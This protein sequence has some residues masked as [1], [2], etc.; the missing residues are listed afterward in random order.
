M[1]DNVSSYAVHAVTNLKCH[2]QEST[3][4]KNTSKLLQKISVPAVIL[5]LCVSFILPGI[6]TADN[7]TLILYYSKTNKTKIVAE[8]LKARIPSARLVEIK[9]DVG[10]MTAVLWHQLF[11]RNACTEPIA[12]DL[13]K[14]DTVILCSPVWLQKISSPMRTVINTVPL[15]GKQVKIFAVCAGHFG[16]GGQEKLKKLIAAKGMNLKGIA[17]I[18]AGGKTDEEIRRQTREQFNNTAS[19]LALER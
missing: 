7:A 14:Y 15:E 3:A 17:V 1:L 13:N 9:S 11:N 18:K 4:M 12:V 19:P 2:Q 6:V 8:E 10:I 16:E 5:L